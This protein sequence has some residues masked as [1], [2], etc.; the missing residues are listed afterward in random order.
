[1]RADFQR[2]HALSGA[3]INGSNLNLG[4]HTGEN[5]PTSSFE[6]QIFFGGRAAFRKKEKKKDAGPM[7]QFHDHIAHKD[8]M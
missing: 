3:K 6:F 1:M 7:K 5:A 4:I 8:V 2:S